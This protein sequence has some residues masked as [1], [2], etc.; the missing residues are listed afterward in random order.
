MA[1]H[2]VLNVNDLIRD[3]IRDAV[4]KEREACAKLVESMWIDASEECNLQTYGIGSGV[5]LAANELAARIR[6]RGGK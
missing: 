2:H 3:L 4:E 6:A 1:V 5:G